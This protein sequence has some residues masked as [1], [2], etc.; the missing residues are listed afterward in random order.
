MSSAEC[1]SRPASVTSSTTA[2][3]TAASTPIRSSTPINMGE[4]GCRPSASRGCAAG[5]AAGG[6]RG[7]GGPEAPAR[8]DGG[9]R[10]GESAIAQVG[11]RR[12]GGHRASGIVSAGCGGLARPRSRRGARP[13]APA[14]RRN[15]PRRRSRAPGER[16]SRQLLGDRVVVGGGR[17][18]LSFSRRIASSARVEPS[19]GRRPVSSWYTTT[20]SA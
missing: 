14:R 10:C 3:I 4:R 15:A 19:H 8:R 9:P 13:R 20:P 17:E 18:R 2:A 6:W 7:A 5:R 1:V 16:R 12:A 11:G